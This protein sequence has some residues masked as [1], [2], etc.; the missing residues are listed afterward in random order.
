MIMIKLLLFWVGS[1]LLYNVITT[2]AAAVA[3]GTR[4][5]AIFNFGDSISDTGNFLLAGASMYPAVKNLPYGET[6]FGRPT[7]R[8]SDGRLIIDFVAEALGMPKLPPYL[9]IAKEENH[10]SRGVNFAVA[11]AT[12]LDSKFFYDKN[13][14][15]VWTNDSLSVQLEWFKKLKPSLCANKQE[16]EDYLKKSLFFVGEIGGNDFNYPF[17][18]RTTIQQLK[19][20]VPLVIQSVINAATVLINEGATEL[21]V[22]GNFPIGCNP[23]Y[24]TVFQS[25]NKA[26]YDPKTGCLI[27]Y[28]DFIKSFNDQL[29][30]ALNDLRPKYPHV[31]ISYADYYGAAMQLFDSGDKETM[32]K[33]CCGGG[34]PYNY[35]NAVRCGEV[36]STACKNPS[37]YV[38][39]DGPH[40]TEAAYRD[41]AA[42]LIN[43]GPFAVPSLSNCMPPNY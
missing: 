31:S 28:N 33:V 5:E 27:A 2:S 6:T 22:P 40:F 20:T 23:I 17:F 43:V 11:G 34:G 3:G 39:W 30:L 9:A 1:C 19:P 12:A 25:P 42:K 7:G 24:L 29:Q 41:I 21:V 8:F 32:L 4:Y 37:E 36:G 10:K 14:T 26:D 38:N 18:L 15:N 35:N 13:I 16:C